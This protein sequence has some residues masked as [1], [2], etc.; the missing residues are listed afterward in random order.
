MNIRVKPHSGDC[1]WF[2]LMWGEV[3]CAVKGVIA[4]GELCGRNYKH[5]YLSAGILSIGGLSGGIVS[6]GGLSIALLFLGVDASI[7]R[8]HSDGRTGGWI[9]CSRRSGQYLAFIHS[10]MR[11]TRVAAGGGPEV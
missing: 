10:R 2:I 6:I 8:N 4:V 1:R 5:R 3:W 11:R 7:N 9:F